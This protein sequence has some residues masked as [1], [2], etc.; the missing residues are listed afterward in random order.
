VL[1]LA[2]VRHGAELI[3]ENLG[4][5]PPEVD[6]ALEAHGVVG[7]WPLQL[8]VPAGDPAPPA[9][10]LAVL[11]THDMAPFAAWWAAREP[12]RPTPAATALAELLGDLG[13]SAARHVQVSLEDLWLETRPQNVP[14]TGAE[15]GNWTRRAARTLPEVAEDPEVDLVLD[16]LEAARRTAETLSERSAS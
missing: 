5:V 9:G 3:G 16:G 11:N 8:A 2:A 1:T 4:T 15:A 10:S 6:A 13:A 12:D 7:M 14:G